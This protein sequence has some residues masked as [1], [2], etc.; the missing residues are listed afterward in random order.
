[1]AKKVREFEL[2]AVVDETNGETIYE[3]F[4][5]DVADLAK[6]APQWAIRKQTKTGNVWETSW[7]DGDHKKDNVWDD[8]ATL[9]YT[10]IPLF[11]NYNG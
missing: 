9:T 2:P 7:C 8:R 6:S 4:P 11:S 1:M 3:G 5:D 10:I